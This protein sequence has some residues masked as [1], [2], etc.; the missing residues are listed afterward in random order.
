MKIHSPQRKKGKTK[1]VRQLESDWQQLTTKW[2][3]TPKFYSGKKVVKEI[4]TAPVSNNRAGS[5]H[6][7]IKSVVTPGETCYLKQKKVY[8]G[9]A[10]MGVATMH[11]SN[12][13]PVFSQEEA[14]NISSMRR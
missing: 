14:V 5:N 7:D 6:S 11:K 2:Q 12:A 13:V 9:S 3:N 10:I 1:K 8:T 4:L